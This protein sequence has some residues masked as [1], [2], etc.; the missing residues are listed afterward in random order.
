METKQNFK[1]SLD[2][3]SKKFKCPDC[4]KKTFVLYVNNIS[5]E[6]LDQQVGRCDRDNNCGYHLKPKQYFE[7]KGQKYERYIST[8]TE[9]HT[10]CN[11]IS[12]IPDHILFDSLRGCMETNFALF[13]TS[14]YGYE[15]TSIVL[16][17]YMVG[18][19]ERD[20]GKV[21][22]FYRID[23]H[24]NVRSGK[25][26]YYDPVTGKRKKEIQPTWLHTRF[27][28]FNCQLCFFGLHL[29]NQQIYK[30][31]AIVESEKTAIVASI[32]YP[33]YIWIA[34]GGKTGIKFKEFS[35]LKP[36]A[37]RK[38]VLFPDFGKPDVEGKTPYMK[39]CEIA[40]IIKQN[41]VCDI[42][43]SRI[44]EERLPDSKRAD[45]IDLADVLIKRDVLTG[46]ALHESGYYMKDM[47]SINE[48]K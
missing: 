41:I 12:Y 6:Y 26:M 1:Y 23:E 10:K 28:S 4:G 40:E 9:T 24:D 3:S 44:L 17:K 11:P 45:D 19:S 39:W 13:L 47:I 25:I 34:T 42:S 18:R 35:V 33:S 22:I 16:N 30:P 36:L 8:L 48:L 15:I 27:K 21:S 43:V 5:K 38:I 7:E 32:Y 29:I 46:Y 37:H 31:I 14:L 20:G 2:K